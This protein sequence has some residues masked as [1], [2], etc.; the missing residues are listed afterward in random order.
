MELTP[1][2]NLAIALGLGLLVGLQR[3]WAAKDVAGIRTFPLITVLGALSA[4]LADEYGGW[5]IAADLA[6]LAAILIMGNIARFSRG[7]IDPGVTTE[8]SALVMYAVG[9]VL[10]EGHTAPAIAVGGCVAVLLHWKAPMHRLV[11]RIGEKDLRAIIKMVLI[12]LVILPVLPNKAYGPYEVINPFKI[13]LMVVLIVGISLGAYVAYKMLG[14]R[15]GTVLGGLLG[16]L[17]SSTATTVGYARRSRHK[18][19]SAPLAAVVIVIASTVV[20]G[21]VMVEIALVAPAIL[22][23]IVPPLAVMMVYMGII[24]GIA[25]WRV[26]TPGEA[27]VEQEEPAD[28]IAAIIFGLLYGVVLFGVAVAKDHFGE[29]GLYVVSALSGLTDMDA[30]TLSTAQMVKSGNIESSTG[31]RLILTGSLAN[32]VFKGMAVAT[33]GHPRLLRWVTVLFGLAVAGG[34]VLLFTWP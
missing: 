13:W 32:L 6:G 30:I 4:M 3:E 31:W 24:A 29:S 27:P 17:I 33:L 2:H 25:L 8:V 16:G 22:T 20:F 10:V 5:V 19:D 14:A 9:A 26:Q 18:P 7:H 21:R 11:S 28:L 34:V 12:A 23:S 1:L 15:V